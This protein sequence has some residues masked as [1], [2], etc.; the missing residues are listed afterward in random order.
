MKDEGRRNFSESGRNGF[1]ETAGLSKLK[2]ETLKL[3]GSHRDRHA[4]A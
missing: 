4:E 3:P 2:T 1:A